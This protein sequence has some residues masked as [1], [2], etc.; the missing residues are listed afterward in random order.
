MGSYIRKEGFMSTLTSLS[1]C[2]KATNTSYSP[3][4][5]RFDK[6]MT[7]EGENLVV[8]IA[9]PFSIWVPSL[10][11]SMSQ[12]NSDTCYVYLSI[13]LLFDPPTFTIICDTYAIVLNATCRKMTDYSW[14]K[15]WNKNVTA[16][17]ESTRWICWTVEIYVSK[18][19]K[20]KS[21]RDWEIGKMTE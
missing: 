2:W 10:R 17:N 12:S 16:I 21:E 4:S 20:N 14:N 15:A 18:N 6:W 9:V 5:L 3:H 11:F 13:H 7:V 8:T 1:N 19:Q